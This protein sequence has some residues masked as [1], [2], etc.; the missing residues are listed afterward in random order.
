MNID[1]AFIVIVSG[2]SEITSLAVAE[3]AESSHIKYAVIA[4]RKNSLFTRHRGCVYF[5]DI[6]SH[7]ECWSRLSDVFIEEI[8]KIRLRFSAELVIF[9]TE[10]GSLR[11]LN[12][13]SEE[14]LK[15]AKFSR[16][17]ALKMGG[18]DKAEVIEQLEILKLS[19]RDLDARII[20]SPSEAI[21]VFKTFGND[22]IFK[23]A[24]KPLNMD[25]S[26]LGGQGVKVV[27][28]NSSN[29]DNKSVA[30]RLEQAWSLSERWIAQP[31]LKAGPRMER[32]VCLANGR[33]TR[34]CQVTEELKY[35]NMGGTA[36]WV[37]TEKLKN[38]IPQATAITRALDCVGIC[39]VS[40]LPDEHDQYRLV[41][42]NP[43][44]W[45]QIG[46]VEFAGF[47][48]LSSSIAAL[49]NR[50]ESHQEVQVDIKDWLH[51][52]R[53]FISILS[54]GVSASAAL[55]LG[56]KILSCNTTIAGYSSSF[57]KMKSRILERN[58]RK[59][60]NY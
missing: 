48:I 38:L 34:A 40:F 59:L 12:E 3:A 21:D 5:K 18:V 13:L 27:T 52:E 28:Q 45:L 10:D 30:R 16:A 11:L 2:G 42:L 50:G 60:L 55:S 47:D 7:L 6:S 53:L 4:T 17:R 36:L 37:K 51:L 43:R 44:P 39:E 15:R 31:R 49:L 25:L 24:L 32:S 58:F 1:N 19:N 54:G 20:N 26:G 8:D 29:E 41:E 23:P 22:A 9:P 33:H 46:L 35:P 14:V 57:P 56:K